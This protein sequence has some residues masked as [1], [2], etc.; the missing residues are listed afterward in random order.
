MGAD[1]IGGKERSFFVADQ[2]VAFA[3]MVEA[4]HIGGTEVGR[5]TDFDPTLGIRLGIRPLSVLDRSL[6]GCR[7]L[8]FH[9]VRGIRDLLEHRRKNF[10][11]GGGDGA[12][13]RRAVVFDQLV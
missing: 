3:A 5:G 7:Q 11:P 4:Q 10:P 8:A 12:I 13:G 9:V 2:G 6:P 1:T